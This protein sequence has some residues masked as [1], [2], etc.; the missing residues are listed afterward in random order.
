MILRVCCIVGAVVLLL[1][2]GTAFSGLQDETYKQLEKRLRNL[3]EKQT[4]DARWL[5]SWHPPVGTIMA[6]SGEWPPKKS[7]GDSYRASEI[8]WAVCDG[9]PMS[10]D[11]NQELWNVIGYRWGGEGNG[12]LLPNLRGLFLRG[13]DKDGKMDPESAKRTKAMGSNEVAGAIVGS[14]Q[15]DAT[16]VTFKVKDGEGSHRHAIR[17]GSKMGERDKDS[18][19]QQSTDAG[20]TVA[21]TEPGHGTHNH[22]IE[23]GDVETRPKNAAVHWI[24]KIRSV[25]Q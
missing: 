18:V 12:F 15:N 16:R 24:I 23:G 6:Y 9:T 7:N 25:V 21:A 1:C 13:V 3:E 14:F 4:Q 2:M 19:Y 22:T 5:L 11:D 20:G 8:G 10:K 17:H